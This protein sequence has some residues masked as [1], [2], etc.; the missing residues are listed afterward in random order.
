MS[1]N[2]EQ[3]RTELNKANNAYMGALERFSTSGDKSDSQE[4]R[5]EEHLSGLRDE[6]DRLTMTLEQAISEQTTR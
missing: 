3:L 6:V 4:K 2:I 5:Q 1:T